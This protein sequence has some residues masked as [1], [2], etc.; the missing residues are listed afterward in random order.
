MAF[1]IWELHFPTTGLPTD[2]C[3]ARLTDSRCRVAP[4]GEPAANRLELN[5]TRATIAAVAQNR[6]TKSKCCFCSSANHRPSVCSAPL[7]DTI[8]VVNYLKRRGGALLVFDSS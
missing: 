7:T 2:Q 6:P 8:S 5:G 4:I 1:L 3:E